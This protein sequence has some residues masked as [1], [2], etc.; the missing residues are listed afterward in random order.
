MSSKRRIRRKSCT[1]KRRHLSADDGLRHI[2]SLHKAKGY[3]GRMNVYHCAFCR[4]FHVG[5]SGER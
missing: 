3:T 1:G 5:H 4:F 2:S